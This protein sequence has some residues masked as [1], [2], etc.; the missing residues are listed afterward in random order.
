MENEYAVNKIFEKIDFNQIPLKKGE[1]ENCT[2]VNCNFNSADLSNIIFSECLFTGC[3][4]SMA[5]LTDTAIRETKFR[6]C[7]MLGLKFENC[8]R[9]GLSFTAENCQLNHSSFYQLKFKNAV[10]AHCLLHETDFTESDFTGTVFNDCDFSLAV[11]NHAN[12]EKT[13]FRTSYNYSINPENNRI[14]KAKFS[15]PAVTGLLDTYDI[16]IEDI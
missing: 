3:N 9:F 8:N 7:K 14:K 13:D 2:F 15:L 16:E 6:E 10:F 1:Y 12:L 5:V 11:F 4:L